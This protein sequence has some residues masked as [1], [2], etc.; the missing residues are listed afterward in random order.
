MAAEDA[1]IS[2]N[3]GKQILN[4]HGPRVEVGKAREK[5]S[6]ALADLR[7][8]CSL[9]DIHKQCVLGKRPV[10]G[11]ATR[12]F[13]L[14]QKEDEGFISIWEN[15][16][17]PLLSRILRP[18]V[19]TDYSACFTRKGVEERTATPCI[20][21]ES[22]EIPSKSDKK[23]IKTEIEKLLHDKL[24]FTMPKLHFCKGR[25]AYLAAKDY[26][27]DEEDE[28]EE[29]DDDFF[30]PEKHYWKEVGMSA[31][32]GLMG[33]RSVSAT[34]G[35]YIFVDGKRY[36]LLVDHFIQKSLSRMD[37]Q[38]G[39]D[40]ILTSPSLAD[41]RQG[42]HHHEKIAGKY[43]AV[44]RTVFNVGKKDISL[45]DIRKFLKDRCLQKILE[46]HT[47]DDIH[48]FIQ[49]RFHLE[50]VGKDKG[51]EN[52][53]LG[54]IT[55][56]C[57]DGGRSTTRL[58]VHPKP[59]V[60]GKNFIKMDWALGAVTAVGRVG[61]NRHRYRQSSENP[62][63]L[64]YTSKSPGSWCQYTCA[65]E[66]GAKVQYVGRTSGLRQGEISATRMLVVKDKV[67]TSEWYM[68]PQ[69]EEKVDEDVCAG[70][71]G[72]WVV[73][74][75]N[76]HLMA[77]LW[78]NA[79]GML[80]VSPIEEVFKDIREVTHAKEVSLLRS[81]KPCTGSNAVSYTDICEDEESRPGQRVRRFRRSKVT[82]LTPLRL[83]LKNLEETLPQP[84][85]ATSE[86]T[87]Q[88]Q[89]T[90]ET[91]S[92]EASLQ[93]PPISSPVPSLVSSSSS[94]L[95]RGTPS[96]SSLSGRCSPSTPVQRDMSG[97]FPR[98]LDPS[99]P[100][101]ILSGDNP[102]QLSQEPENDQQLFHKPPR[103]A[104]PVTTSM[105]TKKKKHSVQYL[106]R[107][108]MPSETDVVRAVTGGALAA[109]RPLR[110]LSK[111]STFPM[112]DAC[113]MAAALPPAFA[114]RAF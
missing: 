102:P 69:G 24:W 36:L 32:I 22:P 50:E 34:S 76:K 113:N 88:E 46:K 72:A 105:P 42:R 20:E 29:D 103:E 6:K 59:G 77:Q 9:D 80:L 91:S 10:P 68:I 87:T 23:E 12:T 49:S 8:K 14:R 56:R 98:I 100:P 17:L 19:G 31:S 55:H 65:L 112:L 75:T 66:P 48:K 83:L 111:S 89:A 60:N 82:T 101:L 97:P 26:L 27:E 21:I 51:D 39:D 43:E 61:E 90:T 13:S 99:S 92:L 11:N 38:S 63:Q 53:L 35:G 84:L 78:G 96:P 4:L 73:K 94:S 18:L 95:G 58:S 16:I 85:I 37:G 5:A 40:L 44:S 110:P 15:S 81:Y 41:V 25:M 62:D 70:D 93:L 47:G 2:Y 57:S 107:D 52:F 71:S 108:T 114:T 67:E 54:E 33:A 106:L 45:Q 7:K 1:Y 3:F 74:S 86:N 104:P 64:D 30:E 79:R 109:P 28:D